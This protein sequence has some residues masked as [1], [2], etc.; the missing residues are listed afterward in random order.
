MKGCIKVDDKR[1]KNYEYTKV[2]LITIPVFNG[3]IKKWRKKKKV[4]SAPAM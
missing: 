3:E 4:S 2:H 1:P